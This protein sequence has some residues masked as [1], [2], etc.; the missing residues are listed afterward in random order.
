MKNNLNESIY[1]QVQIRPLDI[2]ERDLARIFEQVRFD[3]RLMKVATE[4]VRDFSW[5]INPQI[6]NKCLKINK[7]PFAIKPALYAIIKNFSFPSAEVKL[8]FIKWYEKVAAGLK[9][10][11]PQL[12]YIGLYKIGSKSMEREVNKVI[13]SFKTFNLFS[14]DIP[15]NKAIP[16]TVKTKEIL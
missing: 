7:S 4:Y 2:G 3:P 16:G 6:F 5:N 1:H 10:P 13:D 9:D 12:F 11:S 14:K 8:D 15:V